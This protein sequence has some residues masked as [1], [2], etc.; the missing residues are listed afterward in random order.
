VP[1]RNSATR[2][3]GLAQ[4][5]HWL[6]FL[7]MLGSFGLGLS[8]VDLEVSPQRIRMVGWH[9]SVGV[10]ILALAFLRLAWRS[11]SPPPVLPAAIPAWERAGAHASHWLLYF[12]MFA[13]PVSGW[14]MSSA[15]GFATVYLGIARL[16]DL[17][18]RDRELGETLKLVH[19]WLNK[20]LLAMIV[21]HAAA[22]LK[23]HFWDKDDVLRRM[24]PALLLLIFPLVA[25]SQQRDV[26]PKRGKIT[27]VYKLEKTVVVEGAFPK[28]RAQIAFDEKNL[29]KSNV[30]LEID[31]LATDTGNADGDKEVQ[32]PRWFD[33]ANNPRASFTSESIRRAGNAYEAVGKVTIKGKTRDLTVPFSFAGQTALGKFVI[34]RL[35]FG[36]GDGQW[37]DVSQVADEVE[38]RFNIVL[39]QEKK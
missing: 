11:A 33:T 4:T 22:A 10:T 24:L 16:P 13:V 35:E 34:K 29:A 21:L 39:G 32:R 6:V 20:G 31:L 23:H 2:Y 25:F 19:F 12:F 1:L 30:R 7:L 27:F 8:M 14:L 28:W 15:L 3:G 9:K 36:V 38:V 17:L 26:D 5:L 37:A 18:T